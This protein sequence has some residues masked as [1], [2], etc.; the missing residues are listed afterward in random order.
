MK[1]AYL[2]WYKIDAYAPTE[3]VYIV[4][5]SVKQAQ[6][7]WVHQGYT[8]MYDYCF[9]PIDYIEETDFLK[10]HNVGDTLGQY[11]TI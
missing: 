8:H 3:Y 11:A 1:K 2:F 5:L 9:N 4:A 6:F 7:Y 10:P